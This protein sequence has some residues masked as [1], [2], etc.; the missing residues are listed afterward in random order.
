MSA[1]TAIMLSRQMPIPDR[2]SCTTSAELLAYHARISNA[3]NRDNHL[4]G[5]KLIKRLV[6]DQEWSPLDMVNCAFEIKTSRRISRQIL[7]HWSMRFQEFSYRWAVMPD[8]EPYFTLARLRDPKNRGATLPAS[9]DVIEG[10]YSDQEEIWSQAKARY[11]RA[12]AE[13]QHPESACVVLPEGM[14][15][16]LLNVNASVRSW[17][18][19]SALRRKPNTQVEHRL[20]A[21]QV[22]SEL[23]A[24]YPQLKESK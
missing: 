5:P 21:E 12:L 17:L 10:W 15:P 4:T 2:T 3:A 18:H 20:I 1:H 23:Q 7:R 16:S 13:G 9:Q 19:Y 24:E 8:E 22:W 11:N 6:E 14:A